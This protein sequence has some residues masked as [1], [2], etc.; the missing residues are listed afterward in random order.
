MIVSGMNTY[1]HTYT[2]VVCDGKMV[3][4]IYIYIYKIKNSENISL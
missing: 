1:T 3:K 2:H 4:H